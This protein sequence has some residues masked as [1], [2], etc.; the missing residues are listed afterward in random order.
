MH[1]SIPGAVLL[2]V[3]LS[4]LLQRDAGITA[5]PQGTAILAVEDARAPTPQ[6]VAVLIESAASSNQQFQLAAI[7]ALG[8]LERRDVVTSLLPYLASPRAATRAEAAFAIAQAMRGAPLPLDAA[9]TQID[10]VLGTLL[11]AAKVERE[12]VPLGEIARSL[13]RLPYDRAEQAGS[14]EAMIRQ[15]L[16][17]SKDLALVR[18]TRGDAIPALTG[19]VAGAEQIARLHFRLYPPSEALVAILRDLA[20]GDASGVPSSEMPSPSQALQALVAARGVDEETLIFCLRS[21]DDEVRRIA[22]TLLGSGGSPVGGTDRADYLRKGMSDK[23]FAVRYEAVRGYARTHAKTDGCDPLM[24]MLNDTSMHVALAAIDALGDACRGDVNAVN[25]LLGEARTPPNAGSWH[26]EAHA[27]V[28]LAR[29]SPAHTEIPL[30]SHSRHLAWQVRMYAARAAGILNNIEVL[31]RLAADQ[32][33]NVREATLAPLR[34]IRG[35]G[36]E[37]HFVAALG[38]GDYQLLRTAAVEMKGM[39]HTRALAVAL[40]DALKRVTLEKK[41]TSRDTRM[42]IIERLGDIT[43]EDAQNALLPLLR[44]F[45]P[46]VAD[47]AAIT[48]SRLTGGAYQID[49]Q[50]LPRQPLPTAAELAILSGQNAV[51]VMESGKNIELQLNPDAAPMTAVR[52]LRLSNAN[53]FDRLTFHRVVP[54]FVIQGGSPGANEYVGDS[55]YLRDEISREFHDAGAMGLST[56][57]RDTGDAQLFLNLVPNPRLDFDY[58]IFGRVTPTSLARM[59]DVLEGDVIRDVKWVKRVP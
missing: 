7:R 48:L 58:T 36:A 3:A 28:A 47:V 14:A 12:A 35:N 16:S 23:S 59:W 22:V 8:R 31:E 43:G 9:G 45:D 49:P 32:N 5:S 29:L 53:Y 39:G 56:R 17:L 20:N 4:P 55:S 37:A 52:F 25:R 10:G 6:D 46:K 19:A 54:N 40:A 51:L 30:A 34:R 50:P 33:D 21:S 18:K 57:G 15:V 26:R 42:A 13:G 44:D 1:H 41:E 2:L 11:G 24:G 27:M 38:R